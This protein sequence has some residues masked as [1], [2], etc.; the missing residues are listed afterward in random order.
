MWPP[1]RVWFRALAQ[2]LKVE[3]LLW[4]LAGPWLLGLQH[5]NPE[6]NVSTGPGRLV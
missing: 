1:F 5:P 3:Q 6:Q 4:M 2:H